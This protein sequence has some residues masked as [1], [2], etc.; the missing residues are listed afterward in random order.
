MTRFSFP[1]LDEDHQGKI[2]ALGGVMRNSVILSI[3]LLVTM[4][5]GLTACA[6]AAT[7]FE[8]KHWVLES[9]GEEGNLQDV[10]EG[11][12][13][14]AVFDSTERN[15]N[16]SAGCN[17]YFAGYK[18]EDNALT[19]SDIANTE[20]YCLEPEG[21]MEQEQRYLTLLGQA[22]TFAVEDNRLT[23]FTADNEALIFGAQ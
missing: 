14:T 15:I 6:A 12:Q 3:M 1:L 2:L 21:V 17:S 7:A 11:T 16:G 20:M 8:D 19:V 10:L 22:A 9:Y 18:A 13:I 5:S 4:V 23:I